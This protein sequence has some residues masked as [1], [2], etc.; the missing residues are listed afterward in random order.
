[1]ASI[2]VIHWKP[3]EAADG[4]ALLEGAGHT[5]ECGP[6]RSGNLRELR[7]APPDAVVVDLTRLPSQGRDVAVALRSY[8]DTRTVPLV[9]AGG[10]P[11]KVERIRELFPDAAY[12]TWRAIRGTVRKALSGPRPSLEAPVSRMAGYAGTPL[13]RKLGI[14]ANAVVGAVDAPD[15]L[16]RILA[17]LPEGVAVKRQPRGRR[18]VTLWFVRS[19]RDL[20]RRLPRMVPHGEGGGLWIIWP[21]KASGADTDLTQAVVRQRGLDS[22]LVD[23]KIASVDATWSGLRFTVRRPSG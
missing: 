18:D 5:V 8:K 9:F 10:D 15:D 22:G 2:R 7:D 19:Q 20:E 17:P 11:A 12:S 21:K 23:Y 3:A 4:V 1:M 14:E 16:E 13:A 6:I